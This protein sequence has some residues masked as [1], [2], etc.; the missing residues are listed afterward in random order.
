M[1]SCVQNNQM[2]DPEKGIA[3]VHSLADADAH[4]DADADVAGWLS[5][6]FQG[7]IGRRGLACTRVDVMAVSFA[8]PESQIL[9]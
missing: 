2:V 7:A 8:D 6:S 4:A 9:S 3:F 5:V 1:F